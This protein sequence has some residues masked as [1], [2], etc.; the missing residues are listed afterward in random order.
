MPLY[1]HQKKSNDFLIS[2]NRVMVFKE[3]LITVIIM[4]TLVSAALSQRVIDCTKEDALLTY[5]YQNYAAKKITNTVTAEF[6]DKNTD[7]EI[8]SVEKIKY[9]CLFVC[10]NDRV[11]WVDKEP[12][13][14]QFSK[15]SSLI[16]HRI[17]VSM[18]NPALSKV[19]II[20]KNFRQFGIDNNPQVISLKKQI[21][22]VVNPNEIVA[23]NGQLKKLR[24]SISAADEVMLSVKYELDRMESANKMS[25][26]FNLSLEDKTFSETFNSF[27][28]KMVKCFFK[29]TP[30]YAN[31]Y[32]YPVPVYESLAKQ[33]PGFDNNLEMI[34]KKAP[35]GL[36]NGKKTTT[37]FLVHQDKYMVFF[38]KADGTQNIKICREY[39]SPNVMQSEGNNTWDVNFD[40]PCKK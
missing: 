21:V 26:S 34:I 13:I 39:C 8:D 36:Y 10:N 20:G 4:L 37:N 33:I 30:D 2:K 1:Y 28:V 22:A 40:L 29:S 24:D 19:R 18:Q 35:D 3:F 31:L 14:L 11:L 9:S 12:L 5:Y 15:D 27:K 16:S 17:P 32:F 38:V 6:T 25:P 23:L 7:L